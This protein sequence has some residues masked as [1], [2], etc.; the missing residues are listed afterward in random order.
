[1]Q[2]YFMLNIGFESI[3]KPNG[4]GIDVVNPGLFNNNNEIVLPNL[5]LRNFIL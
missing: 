4:F 1:M 2:L 5:K 3:F